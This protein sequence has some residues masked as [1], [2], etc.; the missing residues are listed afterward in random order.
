MKEVKKKTV[1]KTK[2]EFKV[3][4]ENQRKQKEEEKQKKGGVDN[5]EK[6]NSLSSRSWIRRQ[7]ILAV[8]A[9]VLL[10]KTGKSRCKKTKHNKIKKGEF[11]TTKQHRR[12]EERD[13]DL[14]HLKT[15]MDLLTKHLLSGKTEKVKAMGSQGRVDSDSE[16]ETNYINNLG[17]FRGNNQGNQG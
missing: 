8:E 7:K 16:E 6:R 13:Q 2:R 4:E 12:D 5:K 10:P 3:R 11:G 15:Q 14:S 1:S 9:S 17:G